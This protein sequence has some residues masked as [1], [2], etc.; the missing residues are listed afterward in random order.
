MTAAAPG[1]GQGN[2]LIRLNAA[3]LKG[4]D[5]R[6]ALHDEDDE[7]RAERDQFEEDYDPNEN[8]AGRSQR[9]GGSADSARVGGFRESTGTRAFLASA[10]K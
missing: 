8:P 10:L 7:T 5:F 6:P 2:W 4:G 3:G 9:I 1:V